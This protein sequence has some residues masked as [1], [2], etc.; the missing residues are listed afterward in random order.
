M[1]GGVK[2]DL[3]PSYERILISSHNAISKHEHSIWHSFPEAM[4]Y[5][6]LWLPGP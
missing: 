2:I 1:Y 3:T 6:M 5:R 4:P